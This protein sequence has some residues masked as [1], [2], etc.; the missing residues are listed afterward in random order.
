MNNDGRV[1]QLPY[2]EIS[3]AI[4][5]DATAKAELD[6]LHAQLQQPSPNRAQVEGHVDRLR[7]VRD[8]GARVAN[9]FDDPETQR[10]IMTITD[11]GL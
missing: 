9:W 1:P 11:A 2:D 5:D 3:G 6:A 10:W 4:G 8:A 7:G